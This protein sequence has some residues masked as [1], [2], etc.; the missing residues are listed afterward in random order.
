MPTS[1]YIET[2][3]LSYNADDA[4]K[5]DIAVYLTQGLADGDERYAPILDM[6]ARTRCCP[7]RA[8]YLLS[9]V[10]SLSN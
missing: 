1:F 7:I 8:S 5:T 9:E 10:M 6:K 4:Q 2:A 3:R